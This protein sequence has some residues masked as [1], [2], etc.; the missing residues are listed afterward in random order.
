MKKITFLVLALMLPLSGFAQKNYTQS[1]IQKRVKE[2]MQK[3][4]YS[5]LHNLKAE[6][7]LMLPTQ[8]EE[9]IYEDGEFVKYGDYYYSY[10]KV[11]NITRNV[12]EDETAAVATDYTYNENNKKITIL[13]TYSESGKPYEN[14]SKR[15]I[16]YD[17]IVTDVITESQSY[18]W[19]EN[20]WLLVSDGHT[21]KRVIT[22]NEKGNVENVE[23][24][25]Y[26]ME[27]YHLQMR[28]TIKYNNDGLAEEFIYEELTYS[29]TGDLVMNEVYRLKDLVWYRTDGQILVLDDYTLFFT[30]GNNRLRKASLY[31]NDELYCKYEATY[32]E[33]GDYSCKVIFDGD[34]LSEEVITKTITDDN[35][36][37]TTLYE[38]YEDAD[39]NG[40]LTES[41]AVYCEK[42][43][44]TIDQYGRI[45]EEIYYMDDEVMYGV[46][47]GYT[48]SP[49]YGSYPIEQVF[50]E[51][52]LELMM[53]VPFLKIVGKNF[54]DVAGVNAVNSD[55]FDG[56]TIIYNLNGTQIN[57]PENRLQP[58]IYIIKNGNKTFKK[59][60]R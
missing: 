2:V 37:Y 54:I 46:Q 33:N 40:K 52:D 1:P 24:Y 19:S 59:V 12:Y 38:A 34:V 35:G 9:W 49:E 11:G 6:S 44:V 14:S 50:S 51:Y 13:E 23:I 4:S 43:V 22:R 21:Y 16:E 28:S 31:T 29:A 55:T 45:S 10:D 7:T 15:L 41:E 5:Q 47:Y 8:E 3:R 27:E 26:F 25:T 39:G 60:V 32:S 42:A 53:Y 56:E 58:G 17:N 48:Y 30:E 18:T 36:S 20:D 57:V